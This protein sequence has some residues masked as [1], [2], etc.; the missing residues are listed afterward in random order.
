MPLIE[1]KIMSKD[2][3]IE[4]DKKFNSLVNTHGR[5][6]VKSGGGWREF[7]AA[8]PKSLVVL[9]DIALERITS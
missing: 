8:C 2:K 3:I 5:E 4:L 1:R 9:N 7:F 6:V